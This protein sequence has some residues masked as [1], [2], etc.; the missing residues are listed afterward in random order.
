MADTVQVVLVAAAGMR[1]LAA[2]VGSFLSRNPAA[3]EG[4]LL[5]GI[6][7][8]A[9]L[10]T[11][12]AAFVVG[13]DQVVLVAV[14]EQMGTF[15]AAFADSNLVGILAASDQMA[16]HLHLNQ[17]LAVQRIAEQWYHQD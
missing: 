15:Q 10:G 5:V 8:A 1:R 11:C 17:Q 4:W 6:V 7:A 9:L 12:L 13:T 2:F 14:V 3:F 16:A